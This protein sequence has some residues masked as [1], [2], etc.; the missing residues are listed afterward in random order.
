MH[1]VLPAG[2]GTLSVSA[3]AY[4]NPN[5]SVKNDNLPIL[6]KSSPQSG[7]N[8]KLANIG[9]QTLINHQR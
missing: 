9:G 8:G 2:A 1:D 3:S 6:N 5:G 7:T 4:K